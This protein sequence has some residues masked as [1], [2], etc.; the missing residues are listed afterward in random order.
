MH[1][2][3][4]NKHMETSNYKGAIQS[5]KDARIKLGYRT[6]RPLLIVSLVYPKFYVS[7]LILISYRSLD[8][9]LMVLR[10]KSNNAFVRPSLQQVA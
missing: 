3:L 6:R 8:G 4:G 5:F 1:L 10:L 2:L 9:I 7:K